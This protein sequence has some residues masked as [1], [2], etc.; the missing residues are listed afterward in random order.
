MSNKILA[1]FLAGCCPHDQGDRCS[2]RVPREC[3]VATLVIPAQ[4]QPDRG[5]VYGIAFASHVERRPLLEQPATTSLISQQE[6]DLDRPCSPR[7]N[8][9]LADTPVARRHARILHHN[10]LRPKTEHDA[11]AEGD[12]A[13][14]PQALD[15][16][17]VARRHMSHYFHHS[18]LRNSARN[19]ILATSTR[20]D[21]QSTATPPCRRQR[22]R[23]ARPAARRSHG[24]DATSFE[25]AGR[26]HFPVDMANCIKQPTEIQQ[27]PTFTTPSITS[28]SDPRSHSP[29]TAHTNWPKNHQ[30]ITLC[31]SH[32]RITIFDG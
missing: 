31:A 22:R 29:I 32:Q 20:Q 19:S 27:D 18:R 3:H 12:A 24:E 8:R 23:A 26:R 15:I 13:R 21:K 25:Q 6:E 9:D 16:S 30:Q 17:K 5:P 11:T 7:S 1:P 2:R 4:Q 28:S 14:H 10:D